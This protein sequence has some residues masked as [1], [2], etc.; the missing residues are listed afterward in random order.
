MEY[1]CVYPYH[2]DRDS[3]GQGRAGQGDRTIAWIVMAARNKAMASLFLRSAMRYVMVFCAAT[4]EFICLVLSI[5]Y[6]YELYI[7]LRG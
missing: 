4:L 2:A 3:L 6:E 1:V 5:V 7:H